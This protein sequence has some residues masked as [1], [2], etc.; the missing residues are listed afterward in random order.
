MHTEDKLQAAAKALLDR[1]P[2]AGSI[3]RHRSGSLYRVQGW[4]VIEATVTPAVAYCRVH[5]SNDQPQP[6]TW[7]DG[8]PWVRPLDEFLDGR[9]TR[10]DES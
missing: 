9:F 5:E 2:H 4:V 7:V 8:L 3:W 1:G 6:A 10:E